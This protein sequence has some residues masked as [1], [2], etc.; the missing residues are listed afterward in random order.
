MQNGFIVKVNLEKGMDNIKL[1]ITFYV[2]T[3]EH[4]SPCDISHIQFHDTAWCIYIFCCVAVKLN[5]VI[6]ATFN[7]VNKWRWN[8]SI[9]KVMPLKSIPFFCGSTFYEGI[10]LCA[11]SLKLFVTTKVFMSINEKVRD[12][13]YANKFSLSISYNCYINC[14]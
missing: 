14:N 3:N 7:A 12:N 2:R 9:F 1:W 10:Q 5:W 6:W 11:L 4:F 13:D 8:E